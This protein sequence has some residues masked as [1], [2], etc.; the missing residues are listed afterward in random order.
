MKICFLVPD[1]VGLRNY[2]YSKL[3]DE[4]PD[5]VEIM[6]LTVLAEGGGYRC[7]PCTPAQDFSCSL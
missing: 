7:G 6:L 4:F 3:I 2:L 5:E 1:G